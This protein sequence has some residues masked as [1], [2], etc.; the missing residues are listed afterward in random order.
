MAPCLALA[1]SQAL[2]AA[3]L[4][5]PRITSPG[6]TRQAARRVRAQATEGASGAVL[7]GVVFEP[8]VEVQSQLTQVPASTT[9]SELSFA[10]QRYSAAAEAGINEQIK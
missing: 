6:P 5:L 9:A 4:P 10:R 1:A 8:F 2:H 7:S 3:A